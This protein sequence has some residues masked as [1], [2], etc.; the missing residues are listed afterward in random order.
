MYEDIADL[1]LE[2]AYKP[3]LV[4]KRDRTNIYKAWATTHT[5]HNMTTRI[6][7]EIVEVNCD[8]DYDW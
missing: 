2:E 1:K 3:D 4:F 5:R 7:Y 6:L 8:P